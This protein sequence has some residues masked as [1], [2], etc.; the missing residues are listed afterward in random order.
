[1][2]TLII[3]ICF[4]FVDFIFIHSVINLLPA[5][6]DGENFVLFN[7]YFCWNKRK[8]TVFIILKRFIPEKAKGFK[9]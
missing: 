8:M 5:Y 2:L 6:I 9:E 3:Y 7:V 1:M 4:F